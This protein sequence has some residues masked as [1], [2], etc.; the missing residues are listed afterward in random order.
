MSCSS[1]TYKVYGNGRMKQTNLTENSPVGPT[2]SP[3]KMKTRRRREMH[4][5]TCIL[6][7]IGAWEAEP[8]QHFKIKNLL[9]LP[10][11][12]QPRHD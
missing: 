12:K 2:D 10:R 7:Q 6:P 4:S 9:K 3:D 8:E 1:Y 5:K 11:T